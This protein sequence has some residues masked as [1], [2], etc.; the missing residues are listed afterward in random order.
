MAERRMQSR[1]L[2]IDFC[3]HHLWWGDLRALVPLDN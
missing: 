3:G 2:L 1:I